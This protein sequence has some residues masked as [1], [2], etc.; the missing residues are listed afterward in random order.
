MVSGIRK[1]GEITL[2]Y[3]RRP[4]NQHVEWRHLAKALAVSF[5]NPS[6]KCDGNDF[7]HC[8]WLQ[9]TFKTTIKGGL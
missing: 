6:H 1:V 2:K 8:R 5:I 9:P 7:C 4:I 3:R